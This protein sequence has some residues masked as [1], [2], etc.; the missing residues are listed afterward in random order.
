MADPPQFASPACSLREVDD[1]YAG[2]WTEEEIAAFLTEL[3]AA[4]SAAIERLRAALPHIRDDR[5]HATLRGVLEAH[6]WT[7]A[8]CEALGAR[9]AGDRE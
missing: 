8:A 5:L 9:S 1:A 2:Y 4:E 6:Q 7:L 3:G